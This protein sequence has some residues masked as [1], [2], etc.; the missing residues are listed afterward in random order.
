MQNI[1]IGKEIP[2]KAVS[3]V[4]FKSIQEIGLNYI[5]VKVHLVLALI[6]VI[7]ALFK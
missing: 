6:V 3:E 4:P 7:C 1:I 2:Q 5:G